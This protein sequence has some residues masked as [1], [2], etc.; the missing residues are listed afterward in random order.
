ML[1]AETWQGIPLP[2]SFDI[3]TLKEFA[4]LKAAKPAESPGELRFL[5]VLSLR[6]FLKFCCICVTSVRC[7]SYPYLRFVFISVLLTTCV[8][9]N[10][11]PFHFRH[12]SYSRSLPFS[13][14]PNLL[15]AKV[16]CF[17]QFFPFSYFLTSVA[18]A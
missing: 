3:I 16:S 4:F 11:S 1:E 17:S 8:A 15:N 14:P 2:S 9:R 6:L 12:F 13:R 18:S 5:A 10:T 7:R